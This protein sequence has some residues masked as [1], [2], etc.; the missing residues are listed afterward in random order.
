MNTKDKG[1]IT[2]SKFI[3]E[4]I[5]LGWNVLIPFGDNC[6]YD[7]VI[8]KDDKMYKIQC[9][10]ARIKN[11]YVMF[12]TCSS[13][14]HRGGKKKDYRE[15][16]DFIAAYCLENDTCYICDVKTV[17][18]TDCQLR[19]KEIGLGRQFRRAK[20]AYNYTLDKFGFN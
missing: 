16:V 7:I 9:K 4:F 3:F 1:N 13:Q 10:T 14:A 11:G 15:D 2:E 18:K 6:R 20:M 12:S 8:E 5:K 17:G 19:L